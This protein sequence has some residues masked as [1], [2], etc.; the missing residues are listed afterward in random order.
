MPE[1]EQNFVFP[2]N[3]TINMIYSWGPTEELHYHGVSRYGGISLDIDQSLRFVQLD[4]GQLHSGEVKWFAIHGIVMWL[5]WGLFPLILIVTGRHLKFLFKIRMWLHIIFGIATV[6][7]TVSYAIYI[8]K[9]KRTLNEDGSIGSQHNFIAKIIFY[10]CII[11]AVLGILSRLVMRFLKWSSSIVFLMKFIHQWSAYLLIIWANYQLYTGMAS[12]NSK[13]T[14]VLFIYHLAAVI[15]LV[16]REVSYQY[17]FEYKHEDKQQLVAKNLPKISQPEFENL[18][19]EGKKYV[20]FDN[21]VIDVTSF[22]S[23]HPGSS[24]VIEQTIGR[25]IGKYFYGAYHL[26]SSASPHKHSSFAARVLTKLAVAEISSPD[27]ELF[28][29]K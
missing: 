22:I 19:K 25:D 20:L 1:S 27:S 28:Y 7:T 18:I 17:K 2:Q 16:I 23:E 15:A 9:Y 6:A 24:Y 8:W 11:H 3:G 10:W 4:N 21:Y 14:Y 13:Y 12:L 5:C 29:S 26:E